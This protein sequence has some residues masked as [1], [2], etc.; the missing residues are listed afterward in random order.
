MK[1]SDIL[2]KLTKLNIP[3]LTSGEVQIII[4]LVTIL[5][6]T[7]LANKVDKIIKELDKLEHPND[8]ISILK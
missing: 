6:A 8:I 4:R 3:S 1:K 5:A 7:H 2:N